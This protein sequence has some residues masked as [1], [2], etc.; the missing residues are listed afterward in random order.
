LRLFAEH[1]P[2]AIAMLDRNMKY[3]VVSRR[4]MEIYHLG[5]QSI[6]GRNHYDV[7]PEISQR[8]IEIHQRCLAGAVERCSEEAFQRADGTTNWLQ[9]E[10]QPWRQAD[11]LIGGIIIF[12][13]DI[14]ERK[15]AQ[16]QIA[17]QAALLEKAH[18]AI[19]VR[20]L[21]G[22][23]LYWNSGAER[24]Y[25]WTRREAIGRNIGELLHADAKTF[26]EANRLAI[27]QGEWHGELQH[28]TKDKRE[29]SVEAGWTLIRDNEGHPKSVL[30]INTDVTA[31][32]KIEIQLTRA[33][34]MESVGT[35]AGGIAHDFNNILLAINGNVK[36]AIADLPSDHPVQES[37][38]VIGEAGG[39]ASD[40]VRRILSFSRPQ[41]L[42]REVIQLQ[43]VVEEALKLVRATLPVTIEFRTAFASDLPTVV[44]DSTQVHQIIVNLAT[45][46]AHAIGRRS[47]S[48][49]FRLETTNIDEEH[50][51]P[52][53][54]LQTGRYVRLKVSDSGC[55][56]DQATV[57]RIFD[58][59][60]TTKGPGEGTGLGL[61]VVHGIMTCHKGAVTVYSEP[62]RGTAFDLYFPA[63]GNAVESAPISSRGVQ[64]ERNERVLYV[65]DEKMLVELAK[66]TLER[67]GY[68]VSGYTDAARAL[69]EFRSSPQAFDVVV[70]DLSMPQ[71][72]GFEFARELLAVRPDTPIVMTSGYVRPEDQEKALRMGLRDLVLKPDTIEQLGRTLDNIFHESK[73]V[74]G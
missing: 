67:L 37:L 18:D 57:G 58:P 29:I 51:N 56:M 17:E 3:L 45:N 63:S 34:R 12:S 43:P 19:L 5:D 74:S 9:W 39:R 72:S 47:G 59:F 60:F 69:E 68:R 26:E 64:R 27:S 62:G 32:K 10:V 22:Q 61:S 14:T 46:A 41:E 4:W 33:Q 15:L 1:G 24:M 52:G 48:I 66:R 65:D 53:L 6:I 73:L 42:K 8:W 54:K 38:V 23:I 20:D 44:A 36:L 13:E 28:L 49:E 25:G 7:F 30:A 31:R 35:L 40:L 21:E 50:A 70:T 11:G 55:G 71:M 16:E 2:A